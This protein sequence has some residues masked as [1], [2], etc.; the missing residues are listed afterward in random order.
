MTRTLRLL[1]V[2]LGVLWALVACDSGSPG[3]VDVD[4]TAARDTGETWGTLGTTEPMGTQVGSE[5]FWGC[6]VDDTEPVEPET[7]IESLGGTPSELLPPRVGA[8]T[9]DVVPEGKTG[10]TKSELTVADE[11][12]YVWVDVKEGAGCADYLHVPVTADF[13]G[14]SLA[15]ALG[16]RPD[17]ARLIAGTSAGLADL[18]ATWGEPEFAASADLAWRLDATVEPTTLSG[19]VAWV[20]CPDAACPNTDVLASVSAAR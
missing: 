8:W 18:Q 2:P 9:L 5:G 19:Q 16:I 10:A 4:D 14:V 6:E 15:G 7:W 20:D 13:S 11:G 3:S 1:A 12:A 17:G